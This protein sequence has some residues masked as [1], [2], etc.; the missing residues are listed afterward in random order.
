MSAAPP[1]LTIARIGSSGDGIGSL[2]DGSACY[3]PRTLPGEVVRVRL[4][5]R[6]GDGQ[7]GRAEA[8]LDAS[9]ERV[10]PPCPHFDQG[11]G[12]CAVQH[13]APAA[14]AAWKRD[15]LVE[16]LSRAGFADAAVGATVTTPPARRRRAD[17]AL[18]RGTR[19]VV[20]GLHLA[21]GAEVLDL[22]VCAV[23]DPR[24]VALFEPLRQLLRQLSALRREGS[25][26]VNLLDS[27]PDLLLRTDRALSAQD[28]MALA[29]FAQ[30]AGIPRIAWALKDAPAEIAAQLGPAGIALSGI[31]V[32]PPPG[33]SCKRVRRARR[34]SWRPC[35]RRC[36]GGWP[37]AGGSPICM[38]GWAR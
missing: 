37:G 16:A 4:A 13:W 27:G 9:A 32:E 34:R 5:G 2:P 30:D 25:A 19:G 26:V 33:P 22:S 8:I 20:V 38:P 28:R 10:A 11:C 23:L 17:L 24:I 6:R 15:R 1:S 21:G 14:Q 7:V 3:V 36:P 18:R 12:G 35:W 31:T 29:R